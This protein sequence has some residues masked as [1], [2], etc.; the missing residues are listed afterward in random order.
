MET[1]NKNYSEYIPFFASIMYISELLAIYTCI[2]YQN[3]VK[4]KYYE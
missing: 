3:P 2:C 1:R 4:Y